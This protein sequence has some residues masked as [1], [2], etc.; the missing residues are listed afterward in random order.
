MSSFRQKMQK[1]SRDHSKRFGS[2]KNNVEYKR[3]IRFGVFG[4]MAENYFLFIYRDIHRSAAY[5][6]AVIF[7]NRPDEMGN[8]VRVLGIEQDGVEQTRNFYVRAALFFL[9]N[10][11]ENT[12]DLA[13]KIMEVFHLATAKIN[14]YIPTK[15]TP[16]PEL[17]NYNFDVSKQ[18]ITYTTIPLKKITRKF[19]SKALLEHL[20]KLQKTA[21]EET[22]E[23]KTT[24]VY[25]GLN[26]KIEYAGLTGEKNVA[27]QPVAVPAKADGEYGNPK[28]ISHKEPHKY[29]FTGLS[30]LIKTVVDQYI[31]LEPPA[32][33]EI[34][35][36]KILNRLYFRALVE[37]FFSMPE[38][39]K[40]CHS[41]EQTGAFN[42]VKTFKFKHIRIRLAPC[43][44]KETI[45]R[46]RMIFTP[47]AGGETLD[48]GDNYTLKT[49]DKD[50][51]IFFTA[52]GGTNYL[53]VPG[54]QEHF[55]EFFHFLEAGHEFYTYDFDKLLDALQAVESEYLTIDSRMLKKY[56]LELKPAPV[57]KICLPDPL[58]EMSLRL[59]VEFDYAGEL[60]K[61]LRKN[62]DKIVCTYDNASKYE[63]MCFALLRTDNLLTRK[64]YYDRDA[65]SIYD[66]YYFQEDD[67]LGWLM[68]R[69]RYYLDKGF[70]LYMEKWKRYIGNTGGRV[71]ISM[72]SDRDWLAF[73]PSLQ[74]PGL[75]DMFVIDTV[76]F[77]QNMVIDKQGMLHLLS[78]SEIDK[79]A[80]MHR[81]GERHGD[82]FRIPA[83][84]HILLQKLY[85]KKMEELPGMKEILESGEKLKEFDK[86]KD[87]P[88]SPAFNGQLRNYQK[89]GFKW[90]RFLRE[91][92]FS[93]CLADDMGL[94]KTVQTLALLQTLKDEKQLKTSLLVAPVSAIPNWEA[95]IEKFAPSL[96]FK[97]HIGIKRDKESGGWEEIDLVITS[98]ATMRND[99]ELFSAFRFDYIILDESQNI[100]NLSSRVSQAARVLQADHR[101][102]LSGTPI[103]NTSM[104]LWTLFDFLMP[105]YMGSHR[106]FQQQFAL[107]LEKEKDSGHA[108]LLKRMIFPFMLR[109]RKEDVEIELPAKTEI[110]TSL[111]MEE[112]Q[113]KLYAETAAYYRQELQNEIEENGVSNSSM[114]ILEGMLRLRQLCLFP[115]IVNEKFKGVP[116]AKFEHFKNLLE[117]ILAED[118]KVLIFSQF[119]ETLKLLRAHCENYGIP[120]SY[121]DGSVNIETR[122]EMIKTFQEDE[123]TRVF[124]LSLK[125]GGVALNLT[126]A[127]YVIIFDPW[128]NPAVEAQAI[129]RS[130]R[131]GQ[132][133]KVFV[134]RMVVKDTIEEKMLEL[135]EEKR[136]LVE[137]IITSD[138]KTFKNLKKEDIL[139]LFK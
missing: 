28:K 81:Y 32:F 20:E 44:K 101:L 71:R 51:Y 127:D 10:E 55:Q 60:K 80:E 12:M 98:Y 123:E 119:V 75:D 29:E 92:N 114:K 74:V 131:I 89:E 100:K 95:E 103:E 91:Y 88:V 3:M 53:A 42:P 26:L 21:E 31:S 40:F 7:L 128:W 102:A 56:K 135:Q 63:E 134:Y 112:E 62:P 137:N 94:G 93:G 1:L 46:L 66:F 72:E 49:V 130:H 96:S 111:Q 126:A 15:T 47:V 70:R 57:L 78:A 109:R 132:T 14:N 83:R 8:P 116:S 18:E 27:F 58:K 104:E 105:G 34:Q 35:R 86:I 37:E 2:S 82:I 124:L 41:P 39:L 73:K 87:Y 121:I 107:P 69:G 33:S 77:E 133:K 79:L 30:P 11:Y 65:G 67:Y 76:D 117:D 45:F 136:E 4:Q 139:S 68:E 108:S 115:Q 138:R 122:A 50:G 48:S 6:G 84:N 43:L 118:H 113:L 59:E 61:F 25:C 110:V 90:L 85:D 23:T 24:G 38:E 97:R 9:E 99:I 129:D 106:W 13:G 52:Q 64:T 17:E 19:E 5:Y 16:D 125:S 120:Y 54:E 22:E 36:I